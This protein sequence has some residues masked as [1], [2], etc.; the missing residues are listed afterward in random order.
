LVLAESGVAWLPSLMWRLDKNWRGLRRE[1]PWLDAPP[2]QVIRDHVK[3][4][5]AP[6]DGPPDA[7]GV[8]RL[9]EQIGSERPLLYASDYPHWHRRDPGES[10]LRHLSEAERANVVRNNALELYRLDA[11]V[12]S[13]HSPAGLDERSSV[14][15]FSTGA[16]RAGERSM[17]RQP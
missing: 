3:L 1:I 6:F 14:G 5:V 11:P 10:L 12:F 8:R 17:R 4:T 15:C 2:S 9:V 7:E 16:G 13:P